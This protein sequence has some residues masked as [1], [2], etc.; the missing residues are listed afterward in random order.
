MNDLE[1]QK[2]LTEN[3]KLPKISLLTLITQI[4][5]GTVFALALA[6]AGAYLWLFIELGS[7]N[8]DLD[9]N[10]L[11]G[12]GYGA[13]IET[14]SGAPE[15]LLGN[16]LVLLGALTGVILIGTRHAL[17][18]SRP[19]AT[20]IAFFVLLVTQL[21]MGSQVIN[22]Q[23]MLIDLV[24]F[25]ISPTAMQPALIAAVGAA[26]GYHLPSLWEKAPKQ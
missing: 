4:L 26:L 2:E 17:G 1:P 21:W 25:Q 16:V 6:G 13:C 12:S 15:L 5:A 10:N 7:V 9:F 18:G 23:S 19:L 24:Q 11:A 3:Q 14:L 22:F 8:C 20:V